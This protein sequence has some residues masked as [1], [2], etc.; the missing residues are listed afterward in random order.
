MTKT[1]LPTCR[2]L[3]AVLREAQRSDNGG[4]GFHMW[5]T[6][7]DRNGLVL[8]IAY[9]G[10]HLGDQWP[11]SRIISAQKANAANGL[12][13]DASHSRRRIFILQCSPAGRCS[14]SR[15]RIRLIPKRCTAV[16]RK[17]MHLTRLFNR[18]QPRRYQRLWRG[19]GA[20]RSRRQDRRRSWGF[21]RLLMRR[22]QHCVEG[23]SPA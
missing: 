9:T 4:L 22:S 3:R 13:L 11:S 17:S 19:S 15:T 21:G 12:S 20:L 10:E 1:S 2:R 14:D 7:V 8:A 16:I 18:S 5:G 23:A 6:I